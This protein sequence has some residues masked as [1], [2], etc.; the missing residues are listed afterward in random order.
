MP[1]VVTLLLAACGTALATGLGA[2]PVFVLGARAKALAPFL[3][4]IASGVMGVAAVVGLLVPALEEGSAA[5]V[6]GGLL[7]GAGF[8]A[9]ARRHLG[10]D[11]G[12]LGRTGPD[13]RISALIF[14]VLFVHSL[15][16]GLAVGTAFASDR[17][18]LSLFVIL[19][20]AIQNIP[21]GT[22]VAIP[23]Q[24]AGFGRARQFWTAVATSA[25]QPVGALI[26]FF[27]VEEIGGLLPISFA[28][29]AGAMLA[30]IAVEMLP[31]AY[32]NQAR[33][34]PSA[35]VVAGAALMAALSLALGV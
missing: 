2:I 34:G 15:P 16:E 9:L 20:I 17:E 4:G 21:E 19:A 12:F 13:A 30:L 7:V 35:G 33:L 31:K 11:A 8:L 27:A 14:L 22:S 23:M 28:F 24:E 10:A 5:E 26:A 29:A 6:V 3:L 18:G 1:E 25:P 32:E